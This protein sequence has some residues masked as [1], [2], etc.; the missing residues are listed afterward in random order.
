MLVRPLRILIFVNEKCSDTFEELCMVHKALGDL[1][2]HLKYFLE[3]HG[4]ASLD[5]FEDYA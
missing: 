2:L 4:L 5:L 1:E 3:I